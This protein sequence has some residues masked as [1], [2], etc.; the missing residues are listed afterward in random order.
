MAIIHNFIVLC[1]FLK[2]I[3]YLCKSEKN[4]DE[5]IL[6][7]DGL[8]YKMCMDCNEEVQKKKLE[9]KGKRLFHTEKDRTCYKCMRFLPVTN[10]TR[11]STGTYFSACKECNKYEFSHTRRAR[12]L[13]AGGKFTQKEFNDLLKNI[14]HVLCVKGNGLIYHYLNIKKFHGLL[15]ILYQSIHCLSKSMVQMTLQIFNL[16]VFLVIQKKGIGCDK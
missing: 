15:I 2:M 13:E 6:R 8:R 9:N 1:Y 16:C 14:T 7:K 5:F 4:E 3:C 10:F 11:R 12:L